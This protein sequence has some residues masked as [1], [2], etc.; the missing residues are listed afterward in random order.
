MKWCRFLVLWGLLVT[1]A[2]PARAGIFFNRKPK[3]DAAERVPTLIYTLRFD[4]DEAKRVAAAEEL[5]NF[6]TNTS[7]EILN[8]LVECLQ[9]DP[10]PSVRLE[11]V[12]S[13]GKLRPVSA[14]A[15]QALEQAAASDPS[16]RV[17]IQA[18]SSLL[19]YRMAGYRSSK[20]PE[21]PTPRT[22]RTDEPPLALPLEQAPTIPPP[23]LPPAAIPPSA[24]PPPPPRA[25]PT[26][27]TGT[28]LPSSLVRPATPL[29]RPLPGGPA[30]A[31]LVPT[32]APTL[33]KPPAPANEGPELTPPK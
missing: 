30:Q 27:P 13:L 1:C 16:V 23:P 9:R 28:N 6:D 15:G 20:T 22:I 10:K 19:Q 7:P 26:L 25:V 3:T 11:A 12:Q 4:Q 14:R 31:P 17:Q 18:R 5:R 29:P 24:V 32:E 2:V 33:Q 21:T 8:A